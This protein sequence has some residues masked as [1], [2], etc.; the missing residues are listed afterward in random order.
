MLNAPVDDDKIDFEKHYRYLKVQNAVLEKLA[1]GRSLTEIFDTLTLG[2]RGEVPDAYPSIFLVDD[3]GT[4]LVNGSAPCFSQEVRDAFRGLVVGPLAGSCGAA[5]YSKKL[6]VVENIETDPRWEGYKEFAVAN[7]LKACTSAPIL[8]CNGNVLGTFA[9]TFTQIHTPTADEIKII[10]YSANLASLV[11]E[12]KRSE[13]NLRLY[14]EEME[15]F[16][17]LASHDL[18]E[19]L[20]KIILFTDRMLTDD[21]EEEKKTDFL[22]RTQSSAKRMYQ[23]TED[24]FQL[25]KVSKEEVSFERV[26]LNE[27]L[28]EVLENLEASISRY[29]GNV[30]SQD[31]PTLEGD[32]VQLQQLLQNLISNS[33]KYHRKGITPRVEVKAACLENGFCEIRVIDNGIGIDPQYADKIF[34]P[35]TRLHDAKSFEGTGIGLAICRKVI[36]RH[37][38]K[39]RIANEPQDGTT[40]VIELPSNQQQ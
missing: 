35:F 10:R 15:N 2:V 18:K 33:L 17:Y 25:A 20:R 19:P 8:G 23:L 11:I 12:Q 16:A 6:V 39:I 34:E 21:I 27:V 1:S 31:L 7:G 3:S 38:G 13:E 29:E 40:V 30:S 5:A 26:D 24:L 36:Q 4:R 28:C 22:R 14:V 37:R 9:L 32:R